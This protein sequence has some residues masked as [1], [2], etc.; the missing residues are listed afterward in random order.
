[1][2]QSVTILLVSMVAVGA[3]LMPVQTQGKEPLRVNE[4]WQKA[5][6]Q[7][8][9]SFPERGGYYTGR[10]AT[11]EF[12]KSAWRAFNEA[13]NMRLAD[14]HPVFRAKRA[15]PSFCS[16]ATYAALIQALVLWDGDGSV[17]RMAWFNLKPLMGIADGINEQ[18]LNQADGEGCWGR[19]NANG[20]GMAVLVADLK[21]GFN[22][23]AYRGAK[24]EALR[25]NSKE[26][27]LSD[28]QWAADPV[29]QQA[30]AGDFMKIF[31][32]RNETD[33]ED[34]GAIIGVDAD[35][36]HL[37]ERGHSAVFLGLTPDG[38]VR[39]WSSNGPGDNPK[40]AG[41]G[42][43]TCSTA[44]IQRVVFTRITAPENFNNARKLAF[45][46][47]HQ[48]LKSLN[49]QAHGTTAELKKYCGIK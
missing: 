6:L 34:T 18:G 48:W 43:A 46:N 19:A 37:Q 3:F 49:G 29:W 31:W 15:T 9:D 35:K 16:Q 23:T 32:N 14:P 10:K 22:F 42:V 25:E 7:A 4:T 26:Q 13:F 24:T 27:Y 36:T 8:V 2:K 44:R 33:G 20:P 21:A 40:E 30:V 39:Y 28:E 12:A 45:N 1:M 17:S 47:T 5:V 11:P 38:E 41:Y